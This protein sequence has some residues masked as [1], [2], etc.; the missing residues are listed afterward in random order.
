MTVKA[1]KSKHNDTQEKK[2][3]KTQLGQASDHHMFKL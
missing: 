2:N 1:Y 3:E